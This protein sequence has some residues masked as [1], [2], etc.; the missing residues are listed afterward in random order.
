HAGTPS[1]LKAFSRWIAPT[2]VLMRKLPIR[3]LA[4]WIGQLSADL[5]RNLLIVY[6]IPL[7]Q[8]VLRH[9]ERSKQ[10]VPERKG[11]RKIGIAALLERGVMPAME[12]RRGED[13]FKR[14]ERPVQVGVDEGGMEGRERSNPQHDV[15]RDACYQQDD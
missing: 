1:G 14:A 13:I 6:A 3:L 15:G 4:E 8:L 9:P 11:A 10:D 5:G 7:R 2:S 12:D